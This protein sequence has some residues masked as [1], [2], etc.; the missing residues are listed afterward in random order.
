MNIGM[1]IIMVIGGLAGILFLLCIWLS[2]FL[3]LLF[4]NF[5]AGFGLERL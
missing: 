3:W 4:R 1:L 2:V 5:I